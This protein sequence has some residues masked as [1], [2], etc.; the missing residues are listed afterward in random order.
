MNALFPS[1]LAGLATALGCL[2]VL[3]AKY[4]G[5]RALALSVR[6]CRSNAGCSD[7]GSH[8]RST[9]T[10]SPLQAVK[11]MIT[12]AGILFRWTAS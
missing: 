10:G 12:G 8:S 6:S 11:G 9:K 2:L 5:Q 1:L 4:P 7:T 3:L